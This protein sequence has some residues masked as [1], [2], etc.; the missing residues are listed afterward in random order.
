MDTIGCDEDKVRMEGPGGVCA[1]RC[2]LCQSVQDHCA[3]SLA[4]SFMWSLYGIQDL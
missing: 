3:S 2:A 1:V 4:P